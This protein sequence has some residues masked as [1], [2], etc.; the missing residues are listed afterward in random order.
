M[1]SHI[2]LNKILELNTRTRVYNLVKEYAG[3]HFREIERKSRLPGSTLKY[4]LNYLTRHEL[5]LEEK[6]KNNIRYFPKEFNTNNK[7][8]LMLLRQEII[9]KILIFLLTNENS[10][11]EEIVRFVKL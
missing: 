1:T 10:S 3:C 5:I 2:V 9:R 8:L 4:H 6:D 7:E 11:H